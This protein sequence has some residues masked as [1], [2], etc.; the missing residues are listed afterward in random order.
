MRLGLGGLLRGFDVC[1]LLLSSKAVDT[2][3]F[4]VSKSVWI[5]DAKGGKFAPDVSGSVTKT[6]FFPTKQLNK[7]RAVWCVFVWFLPAAFWRVHLF[8]VNQK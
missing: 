2:G 6:Y 5:N 3:T 1:S 7:S 8:V 4:E